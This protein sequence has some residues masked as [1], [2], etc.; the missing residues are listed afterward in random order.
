MVVVQF[1]TSQAASM[2][3]MMGAIA[4]D[5]PYPLISSATRDS[6]TPDW[7][8]DTFAFFIRC[9]F[10]CKGIFIYNLTQFNEHPRH[11]RRQALSAH[12]LCH[13]GFFYP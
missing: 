10:E 2:H 7:K 3:L 13:Q 8:I 9:P 5:R 12:Q 11:R 4:A 6:S 1:S